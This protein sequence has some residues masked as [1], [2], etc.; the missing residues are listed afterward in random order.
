MGDLLVKNQIEL[1]RKNQKI[2]ELTQIIEERPNFNEEEI[3]FGER[4]E[5]TEE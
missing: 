2:A 5:Q 3:E 4:L 1:N